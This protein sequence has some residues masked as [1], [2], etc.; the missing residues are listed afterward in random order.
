[1]ESLLIQNLDSSQIFD[2]IN[3]NFWLSLYQYYYYRGFKYIFV[4]KI[5]KLSISYILIFIINFLLNCIEYEKIINNNTNDYKNYYEL[6]YQYYYNIT[7][8]HPYVTNR[9]LSNS[10]IIDYDEF[11]NINNFIHFNNWFPKNIYFIICFILYCIYLLCITIETVRSIIKFWK[12]KKIINNDLNISDDKM[13]FLSWVEI[14]DVINKNKTVLDKLVKNT[15][16]YNSILNVKYD[17]YNISHVLCKQNNLII[18]IFRNRIITLP[19]IS[20]LLEWNIIYCIIEPILDLTNTSNIHLDNFKLDNDIE[21]GVV[22]NEQ[23]Y[24]EYTNYT[25]YNDYNDYK[26][27]KNLY[28]DGTSSNSSS[29]NE[30]DSYIDKNLGGNNVL[31]NDNG[32]LLNNGNYTEQEI[33]AFLNKINTRINIVIIIN[34]IAL[35]FAVVILSI[36]MVLK[37]GEN[38]YHNPKLIYERQVDLKVKWYIRYYNELP[39]IYEERIRKLEKNMDTILKYYKISISEIFYRLLV[40]ILGSIFIILL[41][42]SFI[43]GNNFTNIIVFNNKSIL[44]VISIVGTILLLLRNSDD[45]LILDKEERE[46]I[47]EDI[48][49][50]LISINSNIYR[51]HN[52]EYI[53]KLIKKIYPLKINSIWHEIFYLVTS[54]YYLYLWKKDINKNHKKIIKFIEYHYDFGYVSKNSI[55]TNKVALSDNIHMKLSIKS[56]MDTYNYQFKNIDDIDLYYA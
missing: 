52:K 46:R 12:I 13:N 28:E 32:E 41:L 6:Y 34:L 10:T 9:T 36:Y 21:S 26:P 42:L 23:S 19:K 35:P 16:N 53:I 33:I 5:V 15:V 22:N 38:F 14:L 54:P 49:K 47:I 30:E 8:H 44:W 18:D 55:F 56:F 2:F 39:D 50:E 27:Y 24:V 48:K 20:K 4:N 43:G 51:E 40:F 17:I 31:L 37:Y 29:S 3:D 1:M 25:N 45:K 7:H 11:N